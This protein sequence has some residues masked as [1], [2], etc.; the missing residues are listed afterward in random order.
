MEIRAAF[1]I[2]KSSDD[3]R[4]SVFF[5]LLSKGAKTSGW[6]G[7]VSFRKD[8]SGGQQFSAC[9]QEMIPHLAFLQGLVKAAWGM[10]NQVK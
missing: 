4:I 2:G 7:A 10:K 9:T 5:C 3:E 6:N 1:S 8:Y